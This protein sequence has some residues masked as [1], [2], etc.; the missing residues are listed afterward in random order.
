MKKLILAAMLV[1]FTLT[2]VYASDVVTYENSKGNVTFNHKEHGEK[3]GCE[4]CHAGEPAKIEIDKE[5]A[6]G[7]AC[8]SCHKDKGGPTKCNDCHKK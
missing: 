8:K 6:H 4:A 1:A 5:A 3:L 2:A 7:D